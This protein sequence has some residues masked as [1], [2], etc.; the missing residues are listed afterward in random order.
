MGYTRDVSQIVCPDQVQ[1]C[2]FATLHVHVATL[3]VQNVFCINV[4]Y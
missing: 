2:T 1:V 3:T 4:S